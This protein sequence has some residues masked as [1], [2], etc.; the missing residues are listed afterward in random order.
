MLAYSLNDYFDAEEDA[1]SHHKTSHNF[2][3]EQKL[4]SKISIT[5]IAAILGVMLYIFSQFETKGIMVFFISLIVLWAYS[6]S[7]FHLRNM[8]IFDVVVHALFIISYPY[9]VILYLLDIQWLAIDYF[10]LSI[11]LIGSAI[12]QLENQIR[13]YDLDIINGNNTTIR[14]GIYNSNNLI[15]LLTLVLLVIVS[16]GFFVIESAIIFLPFGLIYSPIIYQRL[17]GQTNEVRSEKQIRIVILLSAAY[18]VLLLFFVL[19]Q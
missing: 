7:P 14:I 2:F 6:S 3:V 13:D 1:M 5:L 9:F 18:G 16:Y 19:L 17:A 8:P 11:F 10:L 15:K 12:I 4:S